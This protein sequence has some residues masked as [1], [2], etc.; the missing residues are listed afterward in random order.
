MEWVT[1]SAMTRWFFSLQFRLTVGFAVVLLLALAAVSFYS[2]FA[3]H[4]E[5]HHLH[6][7]ADETSIAR[8]QEIL[9]GYYETQGSWQGIEGFLERVSFLTGRDMVLMSSGG[10]TLASSKSARR[11]GRQPLSEYHR[12]PIFEG[13]EQVGIVLIGPPAS[14]ATFKRSPGREESSR[15]G[16]EAREILDP[17]LGRFSDTTI[18]SL[19]WS[20][21]GAGAGG[22]LLVSLLSRRMLRSVR[23]L[24]AAAQKLGQGDFSQ[25]V[26]VSDR[27]EIGQ[28]TSTFNTMAEG[29]ESA[30]RQRRNMVADVAHELRTPLSNIRGYV[31][32]LQDGVMEADEATVGSIHRQTMYLSKLVEDLRLLA[33]TEAGDFHLNL[34]SGLLSGVIERAVEAFRPQAQSKGIILALSLDAEGVQSSERLVRMDRTR[35]EQVMNNLLQNAVEHTPEGGSIDVSIAGSDDSVTVTVADT[36]E[37]IAAEHLPHVF[38]RLYR[39]DPSRARSTGGAGLG[40]TIARQL[41]EAHGGTIRAESTPGAGSRFTFSLPLT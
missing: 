27:D 16:E 19:F 37:G 41:V 33:E 9:A 10:D 38:D 17:P 30:E 21:L 11:K 32:A 22:I 26:V 15:L 1:D 20:G 13:S 28:L 40:L 7:A 23:N 36:G 34:E 2:S 35:I 4:R 6:K 18:R 12:T 14:R 31:E 24:T 3:A 25:R 29:L 8:I 39:V 5:V